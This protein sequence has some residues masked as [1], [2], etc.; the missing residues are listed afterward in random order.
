[1][2]GEDGSG[3][4]VVFELG[5]DGKVARVKIEENYVYPER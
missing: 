2:A 4:L 1:M 5:Q 3:E